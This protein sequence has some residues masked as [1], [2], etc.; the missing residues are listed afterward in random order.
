VNIGSRIRKIRLQR[1]LTLEDIAGK[2]GFTR[3][4]LSK[5]EN[6]K[7]TPPVATLTKIASAL[8]TSVASLL[9]DAK[10]E[11]CSLTTASNI[12]SADLIKTRAGYSF[13]PIAGH[14][15]SK[16]M[17]PY[18]FIAKKGQ[19]KR[20]PL[21]HAGEEFVYV[22]SGEMEYRVGSITYTLKIGDS[23][24]FDSAEEHSLLPVSEEVRYLGVFT[25][26]ASN[27]QGKKT[28]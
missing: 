9:D 17:Q 8:K 11:S 7:T 3:S 28:K 25:E 6:N 15:S 16:L 1:H 18:L 5:I 24:Y 12:N 14:R 13:F 22:L 26:Q 19:V 10:S 21:T 2:C 20:T 4:L 23:L 27:D